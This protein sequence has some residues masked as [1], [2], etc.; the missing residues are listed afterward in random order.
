MTAKRFL[1]AVS[2]ALSLAVLPACAT[3]QTW[4]KGVPREAASLPSEAARRTEYKHFVIRDV[5]TI[6]G[7]NYFQVQG[8]GDKEP[9]LYSASSFYPVIQEVCPK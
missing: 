7:K 3:V 4:D 2:L 6:R 9:Q 1:S 5:G 8:D